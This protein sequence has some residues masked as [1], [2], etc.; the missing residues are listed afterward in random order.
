[1]RLAYPIDVRAMTAEEGCGYLVEFP[2]WDGAVTDGEDMAEALENARDCLDELLADRV[3]RRAPIPRPSPG[4]NRRLVGPEAG[5][6]LKAALWIGLH[7]NGVG[8]T[9]LADMLGDMTEDEVQRLLNPRLR[10]RT[11]RIHRALATLG[12]RVVVEVEDAA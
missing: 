10:A 3:R 2:D 9:E 6:A 12:K 1:M 5:M 8:A 11:E 4:G 7:E